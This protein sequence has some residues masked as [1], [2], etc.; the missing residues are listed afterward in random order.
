MKF[1][2]NKVLLWNNSVEDIILKKKEIPQQLPKEYICTIGRPSYQKNTELLVDT[3]FRVK[4]NT[5]K[6]TSRY[7]GNRILFPIF[8]KN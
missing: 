8:G 6:Y 7:F 1:N 2:K 4:K 3:I 5:K